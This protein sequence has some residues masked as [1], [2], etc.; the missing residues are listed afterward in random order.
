MRGIPLKK[1]SVRDLRG[2]IVAFNRADKVSAWPKQKCIEWL[3][4]K[5]IHD[6]NVGNFCRA[7]LR[8]VIKKNSDGFAVGLSYDRMVDVVKSHFPHSAVTDRHFSWYAT[9]MRAAGETIPVY[10]EDK[11]ERK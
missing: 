9:S 4:E 1:M 8:V 5:R 11:E 3:I 7:L 6:I 10:R 2:T